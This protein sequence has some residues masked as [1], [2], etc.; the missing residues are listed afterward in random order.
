MQISLTIN[1]T[2]T[3]T[4]ADKDETLLNVLR[5]NNIISAKCGCTKGVCGS[6]T[7]LINDK[8][9]PACLV[10]IGSITSQSIITL[11]QFSLTNEYEDIMQGLSQANVSLCGFCDAGKIFAIHEIIN[12][13]ETPTRNAILRRLRT[14]TCFCTNIELLI[15][16]IFKAYDIRLERKGK[17]EYGRK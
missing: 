8:P 11:E 16:A 6:C 14:F 12:E 3:T 13:N 17:V 4:E 5:K 2:V 1:N 15:D 7:V 9:V 10:P